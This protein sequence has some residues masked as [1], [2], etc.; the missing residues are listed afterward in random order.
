MRLLNSTSHQLPQKK[1]IKIDELKD[2]GYSFYRIKK[3]VEENILKKLTR[4][5]YEN[6]IYE[7][8]E[9]DFY[10]V[11]AYVPRGVICLISSAIYWQLTTERSRAIDV[12]IP[13]SDRFYT[14]PEW[15]QIQLYYY[16]DMRYKI[17]I[18]TI[19]EDSN[20]FSIYDPE[21]TVIDILQYRERLG[22]EVA[23]EVLVQ[24]LAKKNRN[25][26]K[27]YRYAK[28]LG[29]SKT[30]RTYLEVLL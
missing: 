18:V 1:I 28:E 25:L 16:S 6:L 24:Y 5:S 27:L 21:K 11:D 14:K 22:I 15:P 9:S 20:Q 13:R 12:A 19:D 10:Y 3:L 17:G 8:D 4:K 23:K 29:N 30:L 26:N 2:M 7:G